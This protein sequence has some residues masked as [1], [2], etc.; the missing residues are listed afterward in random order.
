MMIPSHPYRGLGLALVAGLLL[1]PVGDL[2]AAK[3]GD[4][5]DIRLWEQLA[6]FFSLRDPSVRYTLA[7]SLFLGTCCGLLGSFIVV[8]KL[9]LMGDTLS[10]AVLPGVALGFLWTMT[11]NPW[12]IFL[13]ATLAG[14]LGTVVVHWI[15]TTTHIKEDSAM[16]LVLSGFYAVGICLF[17]MIQQLPT[18]NKA[19]LD[20]FMFG[21][22]AALGADDLWMIGIITSLSLIA[23]ILFYKEFL[24]TSFDFGFAQ[25][26]GLS[27]RFFHYLIMLLLALSVVIAL[28][29]V[30]IVLV[31]ALLITPAATAFLLTD[32]MHR[33]LIYASLFGMGAGIAGAFLSYLG[34]SLPTGPFIIVAA[35]T[36][37]GLAL[38]FG[39][40]YGI[41]PRWI[42]NLSRNRRIQVEN[43]LKAVYQVR[44]QNHFSQD[45]IT[46]KALGDRRN[47][48][49]AEAEREIRQL[50]RRGLAT[51]EKTE[52][53]EA[54][55]PNRKIFLTSSGWETA[56][57]IVRNHRLW[58]LYLTESVR[59]RADHVH[60]DAEEIEHLLGEDTVRQ[61]ERSLNYPTRDPHGKLIPSL[62]DLNQTSFAGPS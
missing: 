46:V 31:S 37:F 20:K 2:S 21:Q 6:R 32:R 51:L 60:D 11:K 62:R 5:S 36:L 29:A 42:R 9:S 57:R 52:P 8:R 22:A 28:Q 48:S 3:I 23:I 16:G 53:A 40:R 47:L 55:S 41:L 24:I 39:N 35:S 49:P 30:G 19:G 43:T 56:C 1:L 45:G 38:L 25:A 34:N 59:Y 33:M 50:V 58:E 15:H 4:L 26:L 12:A 27:A 17:T 7:A 54:R 13:G 10:H 18:G 61:L 44:E 14:L